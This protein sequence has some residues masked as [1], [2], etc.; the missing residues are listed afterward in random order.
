VEVFSDPM[1]HSIAG[2]SFGENIK[3]SDLPIVIDVENKSLKEIVTEIV[4]Q[5]AATT[6]PWTVKWRLKPDNLHL[7]DERVN[8]TAEAEFGAFLNMLS[9]RVRNMTGTSLYFKTFNQSRV[10]MI[11]D[12]YY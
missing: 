12:T 10:L 7:M 11:A 5:A 2:G 4:S 6:G 9:E 3:L 8:L 1:Q